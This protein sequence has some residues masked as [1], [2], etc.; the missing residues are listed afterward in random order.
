MKAVDNVLTEA[1]ESE[2]DKLYIFGFSRGSAT[3]RKYSAKL[4]EEGLKKKV[5][6]F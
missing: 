6:Q 4:N 2:D 1:V 3:A 5:D